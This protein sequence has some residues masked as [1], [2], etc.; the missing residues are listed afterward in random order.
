[1]QPIPSFTPQIPQNQG[2]PQTPFGGLFGGASSFTP[3]TTKAIKISRPDGTTVDLKKEAV[4]VAPKPT[5]SASSS[6]L[7]TP[8]TPIN[9]GQLGE[10]PK[11]KV[12]TLPVIVRLESED[13]KK[14]RLEEEARKE[15]IRK[16]EEKEDIERKERKERSAREEEERKN[17]EKE[18][19]EMVSKISRWALTAG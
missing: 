19:A 17:R 7:A 13:Q 14:A 9:D 5:P 16:E 4:A 6:G 2:P 10:P 8:E 12:P 15:R 11:K 1:M 18:A 3:R